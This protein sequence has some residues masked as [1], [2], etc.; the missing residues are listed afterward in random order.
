MVY[1][2]LEIWRGVRIFGHRTTQHRAQTIKWVRNEIHPQAEEIV[3]VQDDLNMHT[4]AP[5]YEAFTR[6]EA[7]RL[8][9]RM[10][11]YYTPKHGSWLKMAEI[12]IGVA[13]HQCLDHRIGD[14]ATL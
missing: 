9:E 11:W 2:P 1:A 10:E 5:L 3:L 7:I 14:L 8:K 6:E 12:E 4:P 13:Q